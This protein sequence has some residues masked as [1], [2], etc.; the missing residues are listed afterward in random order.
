MFQV[1]F[2]IYVNI[3]YNL[4]LYSKYFLLLFAFKKRLKWEKG[5]ITFTQCY[6]EV[7]IRIRIATNADPKLSGLEKTR[8]FLTQPS[9]FF[10]GFFLYICPQKRE[11]L[12]FFQFQEYF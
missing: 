6:G 9:V 5:K 10:W 3:F 1:C 4:F 8:F 12:G 2:C 7:C 11:F